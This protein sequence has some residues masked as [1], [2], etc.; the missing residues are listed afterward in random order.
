MSILARYLIRATLSYT[1]LVLAILLVLSGVYIFIEQQDDIGVGSY[2]V[3]RALLYVVCTLPQ[4]AFDLLPMAALIGALLGLGNLARSSELIVMRTSGVSVFRMAGWVALGGLLLTALTWGIGDYLAPPLEQYARAQKT[5]AKFNQFSFASNASAWAKD[6][7]TFIA[8]GQQSADNQFGGIY[9]LKFD[10]QHHLLSVGH[11]L[12]ARV[13]DNNR[14]ML[15]DYVESRRD[16]DHIVASSRASAELDTRLAPEFLGLAIV[17][18]TQLTGQELYRYIHH[19]RE[20][21]LDAREYETAFW[22]R[23]ARTT[24]LL[25]VILLAVPFSF[26]PMRSTGGG[27]RA[28]LGILIGAGFFLFARLLEN[29]G[30]V[31]DMSPLLVAWTPTAVMALI[32]GIALARVK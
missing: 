5:F 7:N 14:W 30:V 10:D 13:G 23:I 9:V 24:A 4:Y 22:A 18:P 27:A 31:F 6:E 20:N 16:G 11:A 17:E 8:V 32:T 21:N 2:G 26:G 1:F 28:V 3:G 19:L 25:V 12:G 15:N 29:G